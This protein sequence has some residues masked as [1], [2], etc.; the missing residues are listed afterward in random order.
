M[1]ESEVITWVAHAAGVTLVAVLGY[2]TWDITHLLRAHRRMARVLAEREE[3]RPLLDRVAAR[4]RE[5]GG[6]IRLSE[7]ESLD[8]RD[9]VREGLVHLEPGDRRR[10]AVRLLG[11][12][13]HG[14]AGYLRNLL[15]TSL[16]QV[17]DLRPHA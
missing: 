11:R 6:V 15:C 7:R 10:V 1:S 3:Y 8:V 13:A 2:A 5:N 12:S 16:N 17:E 9:R 14:H 4:A